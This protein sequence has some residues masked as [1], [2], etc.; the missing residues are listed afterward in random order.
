[1]SRRSRA[2][3]LALSAVSLSIVLAPGN[4][5]AEAGSRPTAAIAEFAAA[6]SR[7][8]SVRVFHT[9]IATV[10]HTNARRIGRSLASLRPTWVTGLLRYARNQYPLH[11][12][13]R[14][15]RQIRR[16]VRTQS[17]SAQFDVVLNALQYRT[18]AAIR[19]TMRRLRAKLGNE[20]WFFDFYSTAFKAHPRMVK[21]AIASA[22][23]HGEWI[24]GNVFGLAKHRPLPSRS[25]FFSVQ[26]AGIH[27]NLPAVRRL[28]A[29]TPIVYHLNNDPDKPSS[30]GC[31]FIKRFSDA[32]RRMMLR[33]RAWQQVEYGFRFSYPALYP[34]CLRSRAHGNG[35]FLRAYNAFRHPRVV[36]EI[37]RLL[38]RY[39]FDPSP[40][41][42]T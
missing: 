3:R 31:R 19:L 37:A 35:T 27:L 42:G 33:R 40:L 34:E 22:H 18:P 12:E 14:A 21:A 8:V 17:P 39:D 25:D 10:P 26:D 5:A 20:G 4:G 13:V 7:V 1:M 23:A 16:I 29:R 38:D 32:R 28:A 24:G 6:R 30:G 36:N 9:R 11:G 41:P 2:I 15:W